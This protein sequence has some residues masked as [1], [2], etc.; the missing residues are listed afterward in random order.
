MSFLSSQARVVHDRLDSFT[1][2][3]VYTHCDMSWNC[4]LHGVYGS[5][6]NNIFPTIKIQ[7]YQVKFVPH[8]HYYLKKKKKKEDYSRFIICISPADFIQFNTFLNVAGLTSY[9]HKL[10]Y[11]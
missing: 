10:K 9:N 3:T 4:V 5:V 1:A 6:C 8:T 7:I 11:I 2:L